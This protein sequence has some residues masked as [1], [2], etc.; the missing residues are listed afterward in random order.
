MGATQIAILNFILSLLVLGFLYF[1]RHFHPLVIIV[2]LSLLPLISI[3]RPGVYQSGD[4][5]IHA[6]KTLEFTSS[7]LEGH[8]IPRWAGN[9]N[10]TY[11]YPLWQFTYST[12]YYLTSLLHLFGFSAIS[13]VKLFL[14]FSYLLAGIGMF[15]ICKRHLPDHA[16]LVSAIFYQF[17]PYHLVDLHYRVAM[18]ELSALMIL[19]WCFYFINLKKLLPASLSISFLIL[20]HPALSLLSLPLIILYSRKFPYPLLFGLGLSAFYWLPAI[21][22]SQFTLRSI[23]PFTISFVNFK[24]L[25][26]SPWL[27]GLLFQGPSGQLSPSLGLSHWLIIIPAIYLAFVKKSNLLIFCLLL[28]LLYTFLT[29]RISA[30]VWHQFP[31]LQNTQFSYRLLGILILITSFI[32]GLV[33]SY[34]SPKSPLI[35]ILIVLTVIVSSANWA[36]RTMLPYI[37]DQFLSDNLPYLTAT[38]GMTEGHEAAPKWVNPQNPWHLY[39]PASPITVLSGAADITPLIRSSTKHSYFISVKEPAILQENTLYFPGWTLLANGSPQ[40]FIYP[41]GIITFILPT[42]TYKLDLV[43]ENT[44]IRSL[45]Q[46][47][48]LSVLVFLILLLLYRSKAPILPHKTNSFN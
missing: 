15:L 11:G 13:S 29:T 19:P 23:F 27:F 42:G 12:P 20:S 45:S 33:T 36:N 1:K 5:Q 35:Y 28:F 32:A 46:G 10:G 44:P 38:P 4:M 37:D 17:A 18:G 34:L 3:F 26:F 31:F 8:L 2:I 40:L 16:A 48:S 39:L 24:D 7:L 41:E 9:L 22:E 21:F 14:T 6:T 43:Y 30:P 47:L 25:F